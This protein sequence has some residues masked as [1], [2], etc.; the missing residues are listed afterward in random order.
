[1]EHDFEALASEFLRVLRGRRSQRA[2][3]RRL[4]MK[5]NVA[6]SWESRRRW[7]TASKTLWAA[8]RVGIDVRAALGRFFRAPPSWLGHIEPSSPEAV[9]LLLEDLRGNASIGDLAER[10]GRSRFAVGRWLR[11][12]AEPRLPD[13]LRMIEAASLR[14]LDFIAALVDPNRLPSAR[15]P[16]A[17]LVAA[18]RAAYEMP[19]SHA[20]LRALELEDYSRLEEHRPGW[21]AERV[22]MPASE[23][24]GALEILARAGQIRK[25]SGRWLVDEVR[26]V[27]TSS[28]PE[29]DRE[30]KS[31]WSSVASARVRAGSTGL[32][33]YNLF[34]VSESDLARLRELHLAYFRALRGIVANSEPPERVVLAN[35]QLF[36][37]D[38]DPE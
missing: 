30:L 27:D 35:V 10:A 15:Q 23:E 16:W 13:F 22:G 29:R 24:S 7:P 31:F 26:T 33:S 9:S 19:W 18:R 6:Y 32:F 25:E 2:F 20:V 12:D 36:G 1:M 11:G 4:G 37:L 34:T 14:M 17:R 8:G 21:I 28:E 38:P 5:S 3:S